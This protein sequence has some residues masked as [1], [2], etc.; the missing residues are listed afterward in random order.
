M[1]GSPR[2]PCGAA[3]GLQAALLPVLST[4]RRASRF[5]AM[6]SMNSQHPV[7]SVGPVALAVLSCCQ[8]ARSMRERRIYA[9]GLVTS[10]IGASVTGP[11]AI[12]RYQYGMDEASTAVEHERIQN[13]PRLEGC[14]GGRR[15]KKCRVSSLETGVGQP[16]EA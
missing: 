10:A 1:D 4:Q 14:P 7:S 11:G 12:L 3:R 8:R 16:D 5:A 6:L 9:P 15:A 13:A 2:S